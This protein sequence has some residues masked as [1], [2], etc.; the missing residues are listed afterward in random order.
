M[1][2]CVQ[3]LGCLP[4]SQCRFRIAHSTGLPVRAVVSWRGRGWAFGPRIIRELVAKTLW[5]RQHAFVESRMLCFGGGCRCHRM[6]GERLSLV[7]GSTD[8]ECGLDALTPLGGYRGDPRRP[9]ED[10]TLAD[11]LGEPMVSARSD[12]RA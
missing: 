10:V 7:L 6:R 2:V 4:P 5:L 12:D 1:I 9:N 3:V 11:N 8:G